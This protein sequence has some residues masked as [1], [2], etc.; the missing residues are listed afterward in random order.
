M[1][2]PHCYVQAAYVQHLIIP[3]NPGATSEHLLLTA[4]LDSLYWLQL[5][6]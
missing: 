5:T 1:V 4:S 3:G 6:L 2:L